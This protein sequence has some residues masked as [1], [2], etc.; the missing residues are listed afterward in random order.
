[1]TSYKVF[2]FECSFSYFK[3]KRGLCFSP[4]LNGL[5]IHNSFLNIGFSY[6]SGLLLHR[7]DN[8]ALSL[9]IFFFRIKQRLDYPNKKI[10]KLT[11]IEDGKYRKVI[12]GTYMNIKNGLLGRSRKNWNEYFPHNSLANNF[13]IE[14]KMSVYEERVQ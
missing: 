6:T 11:Y 10:A 8:K 4:C 14:K 2:L 13:Q 9:Y 1:M 7:V 5:T 3:L 12:Y